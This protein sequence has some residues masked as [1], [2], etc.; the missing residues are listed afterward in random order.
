MAD[1]A[2]LKNF[3]IRKMKQNDLDAVLDIYAA[4]REFMRRSGN[5]NQWHDTRPTADEIAGH[6]NAD[7]AYVCV[8]LEDEIVCAFSFDIGKEPSYARIYCGSW[9]DDSSPYGVVHAIASS[10]R[11]KGV[12]TFCL[13]HCYGKCGDIRIDT[14][15]DNKRMRR[16]LEH[17]G[18][19]YCGIIYL[20]DGSERLAYQKCA[21]GE[22]A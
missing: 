11:V 1:R 21:R 5:P 6:L 7:N 10:G 3:R 22:H 14:H 9:L 20:S 18:Y 8:D 17:L 12:A 15:R 13:E 19:T 4:A 2:E 16:L